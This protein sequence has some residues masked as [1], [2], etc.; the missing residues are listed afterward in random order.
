MPQTEQETPQPHLLHGAYFH[1]GEAP[2]YAPDDV[3]GR[4]SA[5][6]AEAAPIPA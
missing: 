1:V 3:G 6:R 5:V 4:F 2:A